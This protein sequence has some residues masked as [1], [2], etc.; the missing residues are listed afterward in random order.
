M[1]SRRPWTER[2]FIGIFPETM[3][4]DQSGDPPNKSI[5]MNMRDVEQK[6]ITLGNPIQCGLRYCSEGIQPDL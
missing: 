5:T 4:T 2:L 1:I 3:F 6:L